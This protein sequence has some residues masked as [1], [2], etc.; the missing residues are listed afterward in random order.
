MK[1]RIDDIP[2]FAEWLEEGKTQ[3]DNMLNGYIEDLQSDI[4]N[5]VAI[6]DFFGPGKDFTPNQEYTN[7][8]ECCRRLA[9][10]VSDLKAI[11]REVQV[12]RILGE[13]G[14]KRPGREVRH[15]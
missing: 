13:A 3:D 12:A 15:D 8:N 4:S 14:M 2:T 11:R 7:V 10:L 5:L 9:H 6:E 1:L